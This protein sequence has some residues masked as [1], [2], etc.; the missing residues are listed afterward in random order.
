MGQIPSTGIVNRAMGTLN[1][2]GE[3]K[4]AIAAPKKKEE[5]KL[6]TCNMARANKYYRQS[7][8]S[9]SEYNMEKQAKKIQIKALGGKAYSAAVRG[10]NSYDQKT[11]N[12]LHGTGA[13]DKA[14][15]IGMA[16]AATAINL[17]P[18]I[19]TT[20][21]AK[22]IERKRY[23]KE[24]EKNP[25]AT[26][27]KV[28]P[29]ILGATV[30]APTIASMIANKSFV[31][32]LRVTKNALFD[33]KADIILDS[34]GGTRDSA[35]VINSIKTVNKGRKDAVNDIINEAKKEKKRAA[36]S[37]SKTLNSE[38]DP[39]KKKEIVKKLK[40]LGENTGNVSKFAYS[41]FEGEEKEA[42]IVDN[43]KNTASKFKPA[44]IVKSVKNFKV[45]IPTVNGQNFKDKMSKNKRSI[46]KDIV[47]GSSLAMLPAAIKGLSRRD[48]KNGWRIDEDFEE[49]NEKEAA[50]K[51]P[52]K[53]VDISGGLADFTTGAA[54]MLGSS[55][56]PAA[57]MKITKRNPYNAFEK[58]KTKEKN[59]K[60][61]NEPVEENPT[62][63]NN[64]LNAKKAE[65]LKEAK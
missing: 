40:R 36:I 10:A 27:N 15:G 53:R 62:N 48:L 38:H 63:T 25:N 12:Y 65:M 39:E 28:Y 5:E 45:P 57:V 4:N 11:L 60:L 26:E 1:V 7:I 3:T 16:T 49:Q 30:A 22:K 23:E 17:V 14:K 2:I 21:A 20:A 51:I 18:A 8:A 9:Q 37:L 33:S 6:E 24:L 54:I 64:N 43:V 47:V 56:V 13:G 46:A 52:T 32:P 61:I 50:F 19:L 58:I 44:N 34:L 41:S 59:Q 35:A 42:G 29:Y 31:A 55:M